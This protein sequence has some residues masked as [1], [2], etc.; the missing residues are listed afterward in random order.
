MLRECGREDDY[1]EINLERDGFAWN[2]L[3]APWVDPSS[4]AYT[5]ASLLNQL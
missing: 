2:P 3:D 5:I 1:I 4:L